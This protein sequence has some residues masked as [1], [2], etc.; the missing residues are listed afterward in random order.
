MLLRTAILD[1][2]EELL[3]TSSAE[4]LSLRGVAARVGITAPAIY[5]HFAGKPELLAAIVERRFAVLAT[6]FD[7]AADALDPGALPIERLIARCRAYCAFGLSSPGHYALVF[8]SG[9]AHLGVDYSGSAGQA[10]F[11]QFVSA[12]AEVDEHRARE[13]AALLWPALHGLVFARSEFSSFPWPPID[14]QV[15]ALV[16]GLVGVSPAR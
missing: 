15:K 11:E 5:P 4:S 8:G 3:A 13:L 12:V 7:D 1:A 9:A 14:D 10:A 2:A 16:V 6:A